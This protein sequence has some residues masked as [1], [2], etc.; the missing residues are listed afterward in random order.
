MILP[1]SHAN[2][3]FFEC[4]DLTAL[5]EFARIAAVGTRCTVA[6]FASEFLE[7]ITGLRFFQ[8]LL[9]AGER[10]FL[11]TCDRHRRPHCTAVHDKNV[12]RARLGNRLNLLAPNN[13]IAKL[14]FDRI[15]DFADGELERCV[16]KFRYHVT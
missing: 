2:A 13:V 4:R 6:V 11:R 7:V 8:Y 16:V 12:L 15:T 10:F 3:A 1:T 9:H 5:R 14:C